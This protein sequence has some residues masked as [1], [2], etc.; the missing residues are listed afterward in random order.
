MQRCDYCGKENEDTTPFCVG[1]GTPLQPQRQAPDPIA[2]QPAESPRL[3]AARATN[4]LIIY[5]LAQFVTGLIAAIFG[6]STSLALGKHLEDPKQLV[7][8]QRAITPYVATIGSIG[9]GL[10]AVAASYL[11]VRNSLK[12]VGPVGAAWVPGSRR[13]I[14]RGLILGLLAG[15]IALVS[16]ILFTPS[17]HSAKFG[18]L[19][20]M[21]LTP[22]LPRVL[23][24]IC[25]LL[26]APP[27]EELLFR[28]VLYGGYRQTF[29]HLKAAALTTAI[30]VLLHSTEWVY[31]P[32][33]AL[34][35]TAL[36]I[37][38]LWLRLRYAA[39]GPAIASHFG[40]NSFIVLVVL[41][42]SRR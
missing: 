15:T 34:G 25:M 35:I 12:D 28:G 2:P 39:I 13:Q 6:A 4:I 10:A 29:G 19:A 5:L 41:I 14:S 22:G 24:V 11:L 23:W 31:F 40:Y 8:F 21:A 27:F 26:V 42:F 16:V 30:F 37:L 33:S 17:A 38:Q 32:I 1:C 20:T 36:A 18:P 3:N 7:Q 9:G